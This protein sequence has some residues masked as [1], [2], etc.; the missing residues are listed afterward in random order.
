[1][2]WVWSQRSRQWRLPLAIG[3]P[4]EVGQTWVER[5]NRTREVLDYS[6]ETQV[7]PGDVLGVSTWS[8]GGYGL[9][10]ASAVA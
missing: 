8:G 3:S 6:A 2:F 7:Q 10:G 4:G 5:S 1:V 9:A